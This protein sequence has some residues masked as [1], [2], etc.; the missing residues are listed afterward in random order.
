MKITNDDVLQIAKLS[1]LNLN[2]EEVNL[3]IKQLN[4]ILG[5]IDKLNEL[6]TV[7]VE[8]TSHVVPLNNVLRDDNKEISL[9]I[10][11]SLLNSPDRF[12]SFYKVP[13]IIE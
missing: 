7:S 11:D 3:F 13:R 9:N 12:K 5:Y 4:D 6:D 8:P 10:E 2:N 1:R